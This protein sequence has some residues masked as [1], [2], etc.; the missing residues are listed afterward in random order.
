[1]SSSPSNSSLNIEDH[2]RYLTLD[3]H[4][5]NNVNC[6]ESAASFNSLGYDNSFDIQKFQRNCSIEIKKIEEDA[7]EFD[8]IGADPPLANALRRCLIAEI[9]GV[10]IEKVM[11]YQNTGVLH[12]EYV[13]HRLGLIPLKIDPLEMDWERPGEERPDGCLK[14]TQVHFQLHAKCKDSDLTVYSGDL[15]WRPADDLEKEHFKNN[16]PRPLHD[17]IIIARL[18]KNQEIFLECWAQKG[19]GKDHAKFSP[20]G[21]AWYRLM[22]KITLTEPVYD[23]EADKLAACCPPGVFAVEPD[24]EDFTG[25]RRKAV[26]ANVRDCTTCRECIDPERGVPGKVKLQKVKD[27]FLFRIETIGQIPA[28]VLF[29]RALQEISQKCAMAVQMLKSG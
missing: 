16:P 7:I 11:I 28:E 26:V 20:V 4:K 10:A 29:E 6:Y 25:K 13:A 23:E 12:D 1:M 18:A 22:P 19:Q 5:A 2:K 9:P 3:Q 17:D 8:L 27:H 21:T 24:M 15:E 14:P